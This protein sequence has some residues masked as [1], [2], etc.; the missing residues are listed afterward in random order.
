M[1]F[2][3]AEIT[4]TALRMEQQEGMATRWK[5]CPNCYWLAYCQLYADCPRPADGIPQI[6]RQDSTECPAPLL[7]DELAPRVADMLTAVLRLGGTNAVIRQL[8][9]LSPIELGL[10]HPAIGVL[11]PRPFAELRPGSVRKKG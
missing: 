8:E 5:V 6:F 1:L 9:H 4:R 11:G 10:D 7:L 3:N 2:L